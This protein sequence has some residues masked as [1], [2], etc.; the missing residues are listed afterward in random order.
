MTAK[1]DAI[2]RWAVDYLRNAEDRRLRPMLEAALERK[3]SASPDERFYT[4]GALLSFENFDRADNARIL[5]VREALQRSVNLVFIR[6]M[7]DIVRHTVFN[8]PG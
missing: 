3:Y 6:L 7:R 2:G 4:G 8:M 1:Q 5:T